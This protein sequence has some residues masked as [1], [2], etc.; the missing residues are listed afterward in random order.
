MPL[1]TCEPTRRRHV[2]RPNANCHPR[3]SSFAAPLHIPN[4]SCTFVREIQTTKPAAVLLV[5]L[6][7][8]TNRILK[9]FPPPRPSCPRDPCLRECT[10]FAPQRRW[11]PLLPRLDQNHLVAPAAARLH[12]L[13]QRLQAAQTPAR[14]TARLDSGRYDADG[15]AS[16]A[17][18]ASGASGRPG[19]HP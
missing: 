8:W 16:A 17:V 2:Y 5:A 14:P 10:A 18:G 1:S 12:R 11:R 19:A 13:A 7:D 6:P 3:S 9:L 15:D 4:V